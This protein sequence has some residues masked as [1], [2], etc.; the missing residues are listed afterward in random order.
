MSRQASLL[1]SA[2]LAVGS[3]SGA[4]E[5]DEAAAAAAWDLVIGLRFNEARQMFEQAPAGTER[6]YGLGLTLLNAQ[7]R[8]RRTLSEARRHF[9]SVVDAEPASDRGIRSRY[10]LA[11]IAQL[12]DYEPSWPEAERGFRELWRDHPEHLFAQLGLAKLALIRLYDPA[13]AGEVGTR[14]AELADMGRALTHPPAVRDFHYF[15][16]IACLS[17]GLSEEAA[18]QHLLQAESVG[19]VQARTR[20]S[21]YV[22]IGEL[23]RRAGRQELAA[24]YYGRFLREFP[25]E[26]R[27]TVIRERLAAMTPENEAGAQ[28]YDYPR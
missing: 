9:E 2:L 23:A 19:I 26:L 24:T 4:V 17:L 13:A 5:R 21:L 28:P 11:R 20:A 10:F 22:R 27:T 1:L 12:H 6:D 14:Y 25:R 18:L 7:P 8:T 16:G 15:M 3:A